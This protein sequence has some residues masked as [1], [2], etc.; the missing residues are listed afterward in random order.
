MLAEVARRK[1]LYDALN[2]KLLHRAGKPVD[3][4]YTALNSLPE[5]TQALFR[6]RSNLTNLK[7][8]SSGKLELLGKCKVQQSTSVFGHHPE[9]G[10]ENKGRRRR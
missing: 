4:Q 5:H 8:Q 10:Q 2:E 9:L 1:W 6:D 3:G 7:I